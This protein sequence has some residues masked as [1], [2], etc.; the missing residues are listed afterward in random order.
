MVGPYEVLYLILSAI[1]PRR[2]VPV[3]VVY[4]RN[5]VLLKSEVVTV[6]E[7]NGTVTV[8]YNTSTGIAEP[9][10]TTVQ[11]TETFTDCPPWGYCCDWTSVSDVASSDIASDSSNVDVLGGL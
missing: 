9:L 4:A 7:D 6:P 10:V 11:K 8:C 5:N 3:Y 1:F 2:R